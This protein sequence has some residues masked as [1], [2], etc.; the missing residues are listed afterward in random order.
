VPGENDQ[1]DPEDDGTDAGET[2]EPFVVDLAPQ[3]DGG[4]DL[5]QAGDDRPGSDHVE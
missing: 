1:Q 5:E 2:E 3:L 4:E